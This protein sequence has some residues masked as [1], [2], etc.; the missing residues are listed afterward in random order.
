MKGRAMASKPR[1]RFTDTQPNDGWIPTAI[2]ALSIAGFD[3][4]TKAAVTA[5]VPLGGLIPI[6][7][8]RVALWHVRNPALVLGLFGDLPLT[9]RMV[10][11]ALLGIAGVVLLLEVFTRSQRL[12]PTRRPWSWVFV[13]LVLG[14]MLG[15][16][17]ERVL[18]WWVT[19]FL[20]FRWG[21]LW[22]PP[23]N[24]ADLAILL[25]LP[26]AP[27]IIGFEIEARRGRGKPNAESSTGSGTLTD[28]R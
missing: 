11:A 9:N 27:I 6:L 24:I 2:I 18:H 15:N 19:D 10:V 12:L 3:W 23:G 28:D 8:G 22:L 13:G 16:L 4:S 26:L 20:S 1:R 25:S 14:G 17:G 7:D 5:F 21:D